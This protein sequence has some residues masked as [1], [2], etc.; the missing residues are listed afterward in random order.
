MKKL[1]KEKSSDGSWKL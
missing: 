1:S